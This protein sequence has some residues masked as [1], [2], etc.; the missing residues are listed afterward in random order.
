MNK[1]APA[2]EGF[3]S[4]KGYKVWYR[5]VGDHEDRGKLPLL[6]LHGGPGASHDYLEPLEAMAATGRRVIFYDQIGAGNSDHPHNPSLWTVPLFV[7]EL[8]VVRQALGLERVHILGQSWGGMLGMEYALTQPRGLAS[9]IV[10][11]SPASMAQWVEEANRLRAELPSDVQ[12][13]LLK[14]EVAGTTDDPAY[15][16]AMLVFYRRHLCR[17][18]PW[19]DCLN[20]TFEKTSKD[21]EV[22]NT[23]NGPSEFHV[24]GVIKDW[25]IVERLG[26]IQVPT[27]VISGRYD[28]ATP[29]IAGTIHHGISGSEWVLFENSSH[30]P[31]IE[32]TERYLHVLTSFLHRVESQVE[33]GN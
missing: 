3:V 26:D 11:D 4:F 23:M 6:C 33:F 13:T 5:I 7:E 22:Y 14:H 1:E 30:M 17:L 25:D 15:Q 29:A 21:P 32:E 28:E 18:D 31:H 2:Q 19:P 10:A 27:L 20:R 24:V 12:E 16:E 8:G 9:L